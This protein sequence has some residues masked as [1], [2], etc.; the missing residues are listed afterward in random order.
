[1]GMI[2]RVDWLAMFIFARFEIVQKYAG[3]ERNPGS[4][5]P[6][7]AESAV[8]QTELPVQ[9]IVRRITA[10]GIADGLRLSQDSVAQVISFAAC[11]PCYGNAERHR[12]LDRS[13]CGCLIPADAVVGDYLDGIAD[14]GVIRQ[15]WRDPRILVIAGASLGTR[16]LPLRSRLWWSFQADRATP[17]MRAVHSQDSFHFDLDDW[18]AVKFFFYMT[19]VGRENGPHIYV[20]NSHR[21]RPMHDQLSPFK[22]RSSHYI[23]SKYGRDNLAVMQGPAGT[24]FVEDPYGFHTGTAVTGASRLMLEIE[25]GVSRTPVVG[26]PFYVPVIE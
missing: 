3:R 20:R 15:L 6:Q 2:Y 11:A 1:M 10:D 16:P 9:E 8:L 25:Y 22:S 4:P 13:P 21:N 14:C 17:E 18:C 5:S 23:T 26:G 12:L 7:A 19:D 24:G